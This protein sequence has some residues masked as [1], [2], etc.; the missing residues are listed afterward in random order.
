MRLSP[1]LR[2]SPFQKFI[3]GLHIFHPPVLSR[4][5]FAQVTPE[6]NKPGVPLRFPLFFP[7]QISSI[8]VSTNIAR[9][10]LSLGDR[11]GFLVRKLVKPTKVFCSGA[12]N[13]TCFSRLWF[14]KAKRD[15]RAVAAGIFAGSEP[16]YEQ[17]VGRLDS[18]NRVLCQLPEFATLFI[19]DCGA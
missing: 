19:S 12:S 16:R 5:H 4:P 6:F 17:E 3:E 2:K 14:P 15:I 18:P 11:G 1:R 7:S 8:L 13:K 9:R 10:R